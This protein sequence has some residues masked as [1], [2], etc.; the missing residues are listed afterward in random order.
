MGRA[1]T[2]QAPSPPTPRSPSLCP[3]LRPH[4]APHCPELTCMPMAESSQGHLSCSV[5]GLTLD[6]VIHKWGWVGPAGFLVPHRW[7]CGVRAP[8]LEQKQRG[9]APLSLNHMIPGPEISG[10]SEYSWSTFCICGALLG[11]TGRWFPD[12]GASQ[13]A[14]SFSRNSQV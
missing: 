14:G 8:T 3:H 1:D 7:V 2:G 11:T 10:L 13:S 4:L 9:N 5:L 6:L 12:T